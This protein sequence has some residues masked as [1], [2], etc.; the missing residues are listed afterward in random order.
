VMHA[1]QPHPTHPDPANPLTRRASRIPPWNKAPEHSSECHRRGF[2]SAPPASHRPPHSFMFGCMRVC[3]CTRAHTH[4][5]I[6]TH[7]KT[8][9]YNEYTQQRKQEAEAGKPRDEGARRLGVAGRETTPTLADSCYSDS[10]LLHIK[11]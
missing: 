2:Q 5:H 9:L 3:A 6:N 7:T 4:K 8:H 10:S 11:V 1:S